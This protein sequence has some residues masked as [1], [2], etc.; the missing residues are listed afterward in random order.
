MH[1]AYE[2]AM[3]ASKTFIG[4]S[5]AVRAIF[6]QALAGSAMLVA[7]AMIPV[8]LDEDG[9]RVVL[10]TAGSCSR[11]SWLWPNRSR[12]TFRGVR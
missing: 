5:D 6:A 1:F 3:A 12:E 9:S 4:S 2:L 8:A 11:I 7:H 10:P